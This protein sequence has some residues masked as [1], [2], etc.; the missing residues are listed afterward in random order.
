M[1]NS[2]M[3]WYENHAQDERDYMERNW[4]YVERVC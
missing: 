1:N 4:P 3:Y 2:E